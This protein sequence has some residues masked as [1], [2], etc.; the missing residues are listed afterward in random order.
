MTEQERL[1]I[2]KY[3]LYFESRLSRL[4]AVYESL[5]GEVKQIKD[6]MNYIKKDMNDIK[7]DMKTDFRWIITLMIMMLGVMA[8]GFHWV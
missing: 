7:K 2:T 3:D 1:S 5:G 4:E 6:E 8:K